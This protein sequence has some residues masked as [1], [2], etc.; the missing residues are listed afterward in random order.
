MPVH[1]EAVAAAMESYH[2]QMQAIEEFRRR[3]ARLTASGSAQGNT[4]TV[5]VNADNLVVETRFADNIGELGYDD[6]AAAVTEAATAASA[7]MAVK[8][9]EITRALIAERRNA[10]E[11]SDLFADLPVFPETGR[12]GT[13][14]ESSERPHG[15]RTATHDDFDTAVARRP[16]R[17]R[18]SDSG[19]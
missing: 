16:V 17:S 5:T 7:A 1:S 10:P 13:A 14:P 19:W 2:R 8:T 9:E 15:D 3:R 6:I 4:V 11:L 12:P 18:I